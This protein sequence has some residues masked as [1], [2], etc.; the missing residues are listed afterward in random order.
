MFIIKI[1]DF[2]PLKMDYICLARKN[3]KKMHQSMKTKKKLI[4]FIFIVLSGALLMGLDHYGLLE[5]YARFALI[6]VIGAY[7]LGQFVTR[8]FDAQKEEEG[9]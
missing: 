3:P 9:Q 1:A 8:K 7:F 2:S 5:K 4:D 6:P